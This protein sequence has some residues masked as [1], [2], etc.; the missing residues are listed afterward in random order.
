MIEIW[1]TFWRT[2]DPRRYKKI[3]GEKCCYWCYERADHHSHACPMAH[4]EWAWYLSVGFIRARLIYRR[5]H[6]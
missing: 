5:T 3:K 4:P 6:R 1:Y 2:L